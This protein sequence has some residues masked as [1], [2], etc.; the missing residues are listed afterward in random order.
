MMAD[1]RQ[2]MI[3][4]ERVKTIIESYGGSS[5]AW[6]EQERKIAMALV[7]AS[8]ELQALC[9]EA[10]RLDGDLERVRSYHKKGT[11]E[12]ATGTLAARILDNLPEQNS[13][14]RTLTNKHQW[15][16]I[17]ITGAI[18]ASL[19]IITLINFSTPDTPRATVV[20][21]N[22]FDQWAWEEVFDE[23]PQS[24]AVIDELAVITYLEPDLNG[25]NF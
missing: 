21:A 7:A 8:S 20:S 25:D 5:D 16:G 18:A 6:P 10:L 24:A 4:V 1:E 19:V 11:A 3:S 13:L 15:L 22:A 2:K 9:D 14:P 17:T 23:T 12:S